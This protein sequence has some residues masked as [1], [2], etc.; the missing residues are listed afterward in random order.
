M[1]MVVE[2]LSA[3]SRA[4][5]TTPKSPNKQTAIQGKPMI[6][7]RQLTR[8]R[9]LKREMYTSP[10]RFNLSLPIIPTEYAAYEPFCTLNMINGIV[11]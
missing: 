2:L 4:G 10:M 8:I 3:D 11:L 6:V 7:E 9:L 5:K 1:M